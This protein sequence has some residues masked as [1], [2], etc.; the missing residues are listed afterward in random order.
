[1]SL[2]SE[3]IHPEGVNVEY[4][5]E[6]ESIHANEKSVENVIKDNEPVKNLIPIEKFISVPKS[7]QSPPPKLEE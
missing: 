1:M 4:V 5:I 3:N 6:N 7:R 2:E